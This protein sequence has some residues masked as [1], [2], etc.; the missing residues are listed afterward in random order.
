MFSSTSVNKSMPALLKGSFF[1]FV[2]QAHYF[3]F[4]KYNKLLKFLQC[5]LPLQHIFSP[6]LLVVVVLFCFVL[7]IK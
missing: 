2:P 6:L 4:D 1:F 3:I 5:H 7:I